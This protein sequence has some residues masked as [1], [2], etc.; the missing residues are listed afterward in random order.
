MQACWTPRRREDG[1]RQEMMSAAF[2]SRAW[3][4]AGVPLVCRGGAR[5]LP[6]I[7]LRPAVASGRPK[8][9]KNLEKASPMAAARRFHQTVTSHDRSG[10]CSSQRRPCSRVLTSHGDGVWP[11]HRQWCHLVRTKVW[12]VLRRIPKVRI[13]PRIRTSSMSQLRSPYAP[14][15]DRGVYRVGWGKIGRKFFS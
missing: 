8:M 2:R 13:H 14:T 12:T 11:L 9:V 15:P 5:T 4:C 6:S 7:R 3:W 1:R 10:C